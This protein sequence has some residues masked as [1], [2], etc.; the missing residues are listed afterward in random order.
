MT[1][2]FLC[3][4]SDVILNHFTFKVSAWNFRVG[5]R[6][7]YQTDDSKSVLDSNFFKLNLTSLQKDC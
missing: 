3:R 4:L 5:L 7:V 2:E 1:F 6:E